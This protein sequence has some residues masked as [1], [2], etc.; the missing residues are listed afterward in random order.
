ML[1]GHSALF[2]MKEETKQTMDYFQK[3][4][5]ATVED[6]YQNALDYMSECL[7]ELEPPV[8]P[9]TSVASASFRAPSSTFSLAH[10]PPIKLPPI[11]GKYEEW[12]IFRDLFHAL[13]VRNRD[14]NNFAR[15]HFLKSCLKGRAA[16]CIADVAITGE[17]FDVAWNA[18]KA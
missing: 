16:D 17:N 6:S 3:D 15:M 13:I 11:D 4:V 10:L 9:N 2:R 14:F 7:E 5:I 18:L 8:S 12:E 1:N